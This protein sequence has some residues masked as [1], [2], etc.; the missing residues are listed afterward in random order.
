MSRKGG[1]SCHPEKPPEPFVPP[2]DEES[3]IACW[4]APKFFNGIPPT[5]KTKR[6]GKQSKKKHIQQVYGFGKPRRFKFKS[7]QKHSGYHKKN[8]VKKRAA[9]SGNYVVTEFADFLCQHRIYSPDCR[10]CQSQSVPKQPLT[11]IVSV[12]SAVSDQSDSNHCRRKS[13]K[14]SCL[15]LFLSLGKYP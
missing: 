4:E 6:G 13:D 10:R 12:P 7:E 5:Y 8:T 1:S 11:Y 3:H 14:E 15:R 9:G 2:A